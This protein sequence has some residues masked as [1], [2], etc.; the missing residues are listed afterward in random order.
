MCWCFIILKSQKHS[1]EFFGFA[2]YSSSQQTILKIYCSHFPVKDVQVLAWWNKIKGYLEHWI[3]FWLNWTIAILILLIINQFYPIIWSGI[4]WWTL[5]YY[6]ILIFFYVR[7]N[8][9][10]CKNLSLEYIFPMNIK[11]EWITKAESGS[12]VY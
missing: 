7:S 10:W 9:I 3:L 6:L 4:S 11:F 12:I 1:S 8:N 2:V 5:N